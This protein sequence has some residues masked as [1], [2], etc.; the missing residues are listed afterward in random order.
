MA[1]ARQKRNT[2]K[3][4]LAELAVLDATSIDDA[5]RLIGVSRCQAYAEIKSGRLKKTKIGGRSLITKRERLRYLA[6]ME[7][8]SNGQA[9]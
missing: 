5:A 6:A 2:E 4:S 9:A 8:E 7:V 1:R 3:Y